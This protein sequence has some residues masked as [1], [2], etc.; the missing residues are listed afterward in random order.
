MLDNVTLSK[1][2]LFHH[3]LSINLKMEV[4]T[5]IILVLFFANINGNNLE[6]GNLEA[7][8]FPDGILMF[9]IV[10]QY[11][12][13]IESEFK[14]VENPKPKRKIFERKRIGKIDSRL[15]LLRK[16]NVNLY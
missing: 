15:R 13:N 2:S 16:R 6:R 1:A 3:I 8:T 4:T 12:M 7:P 5:I 14:V 11:P 9:T 10:H